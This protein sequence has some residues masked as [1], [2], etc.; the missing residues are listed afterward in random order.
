MT[1]KMKG[2]PMHNSAS[3]L[4][5]KEASPM[6]FQEK[7]IDG[8]PVDKQTYMDF[9]KKE[10]DLRRKWEMMEQDGRS[11]DDEI[12]AAKKELEAHLGGSIDMG[13]SAATEDINLGQTRSPR[14]QLTD[15]D[16]YKHMSSIISNEFDVL[17]KRGEDYKGMN[18]SSDNA[19]RNKF[20]MDKGMTQEQIDAFD[21]SRI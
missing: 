20:L 15:D 2:F 3:A 10:K 21:K 13:G 1:F 6:K 9:V 19:A 11:T 17:A 5:Q 18:I 4:K 12:A 7:L 8:I 16:L 14:V